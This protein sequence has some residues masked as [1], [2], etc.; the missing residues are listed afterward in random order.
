M[1]LLKPSVPHLESYIDDLKT[2]DENGWYSNYGPFYHKFKEGLS[3][4]FK[5]TPDNIDLFCNGTMALTAG[6]VALKKEDKPY[7][8]LPSWTFVASAHAVKLAGLTPYFI[9]VDSESMQVSEN[10]LKQIPDSI[11][12]NTS[13]VMIV[14]PFGAPIRDLGLSTF[15][16]KYGI[17]ILV[18]AAGGF[19]S[20]VYS[21]FNTMI[22]LHAT[23][24]FG[25]GEGGLLISRDIKFINRAHQFANFGFTNGSRTS[26]AIGANGKLNEI[27]SVI[28]LA[29]LKMWPDL[30]Q[31]YYDKAKLYLKTK[32]TDSFEFM[33]GW[34]L[35]WVSSTCIVRYKTKQH[36]EEIVKEYNKKNLPYRDW[37][38]KGC[39]MEPIFQH[40]LK[41]ENLD[42]T[43]LLA[44]TT[45]GIMF[46]SDLHN[47]F[48]LSS[49]YE[50]N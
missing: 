29:A 21:N 33:E 14:A 19:D 16:Q 49:F 50:K 13:V 43:T 18:D 23:K 38:N 37:W 44:D 24:A 41:S 15:S 47:D 28:G 4:H 30:R 10:E 48:I 9:D 17:E 22:S 8:I 46:H 40:S 36:K 20:Y 2:I 5:C 6:L 39:H 32:K 26:D 11:L 31:N 7:C 12:I 3:K 1:D 35:Q 27:S 25:I 42:I 34:G 45:L